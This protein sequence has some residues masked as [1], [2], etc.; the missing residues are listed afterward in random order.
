MAWC[1]GQKDLLV[2][3]SER[4]TL[5]KGDALAAGWDVTVKGLPQVDVV[6]AADAVSRV[7]EVQ[8]PRAAV[9]VAPDL[10]FVDN[11]LVNIGAGMGR[12]RNAAQMARAAAMVAGQQQAQQAERIEHVRPL[13][14]RVVF[15][16]SAGRIAALDLANGQ[17][18]WQT[19]AGD[20]PLA[21]LVA[22]DD[23][24]AARFDDETGPQLV[25]LDTF[26]GQVVMRTSFTPDTAPANVA[27]ARTA[28]CSTRVPTASAAR[29]S[30]S[31]AT[32]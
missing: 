26:A 18:A 6:D 13:G 1:N 27:L 17:P 14:D 2:W 20:A 30:T 11:Q 25:A 8:A 9:P 23:F 15:A 7:D 24:I 31:P 32:P 5:L 10:V 28:R 19:R 16:T 3:T 22:N 21:Q 4:L 12:P 29:T